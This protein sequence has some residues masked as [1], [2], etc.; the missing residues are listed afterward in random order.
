MSRARTRVGWMRSCGSKRVLRV[1]NL[2]ISTLLLTGTLLVG[3]SMP[4]PMPT[5]PDTAVGVTASSAS[6]TPT[7]ERI[8]SGD[9]DRR[10]NIARPSRSARSTVLVVQRAAKVPPHLRVWASCVLARE[11]G[12]TLERIQ[13]G[14]GARNPNS[15]ASGRWQ[16]LD[17]SGWREGG[18]WM[19][20]DRLIRFGLPRNQAREVRKWLA[21]HPIY[22]WH[23][24][25]QDIAFVESISRGGWRHWAGHTCGRP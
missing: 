3:I 13:S 25:F 12:G 24:Y 22:T 23:G 1:R 6:P 2:M 9:A 19:V 5:V 18:A 7:V 4:Y 17:G 20:R 8:G 11:S 15:S 16:M 21:S 14:V 10:L